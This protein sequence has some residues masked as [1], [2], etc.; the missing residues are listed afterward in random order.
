M[1]PDFA[2][3]CTRGP[4]T[5][6]VQLKLYKCQFLLNFGLRQ[7][8]HQPL[9]LCRLPPAAAAALC[10]LGADLATGATGASRSAVGLRQ[11]PGCRFLNFCSL[12]V[13][14]AR[15]HWV[16]ACVPMPMRLGVPNLCPHSR[17]CKRWSMWS[18]KCW[19][20]MSCSS[21]KSAW[22][23]R[24]HRWAARAPDRYLPWRASAGWSSFQEVMVSSSRLENPM[25]GPLWQ[26]PS[27]T[28]DVLTKKNGVEQPS[29]SVCG[30]NCQ[31]RS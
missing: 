21:C 25:I 11:R 14:I 7:G 13:T 15:A 5:N 17:T 6:F 8:V 1:P 4:S 31:P 26:L 10:K 16:S 2:S 27:A 23:A 12:P 28:Y 22:Y 30:N 18:K 24:G 9:K 29:D 19:R 3:A 20:M